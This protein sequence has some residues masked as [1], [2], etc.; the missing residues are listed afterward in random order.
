MYGFILLIILVS[1]SSDDLELPSDFTI[2]D[3]VDRNDV[4]PDGTGWQGM[5]VD[6]DSLGIVKVRPQLSTNN[7]DTILFFISSSQKNKFV[8][9]ILDI[10]DKSITSSTLILMIGTNLFKIKNPADNNF[11]RWRI[12]ALDNSFS[13]T[14]KQWFIAKKIS[15]AINY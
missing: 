11:Y 6:L 9:E 13:I 4:N 15:S 5:I 2:V 12:S 7:P 1:C 8:F 3:I 10:H 14:S